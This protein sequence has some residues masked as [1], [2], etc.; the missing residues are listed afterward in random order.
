MNSDD[1]FWVCVW[2]IAGATLVAIVITC[3]VYSHHKNLVINELV[4]NGASPVEALCALDDTMG[5]NPTCV[6]AATKLG[7][8]NGK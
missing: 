1:K 5:D 8:T 6:I 7:V 2:G 3:M 4:K